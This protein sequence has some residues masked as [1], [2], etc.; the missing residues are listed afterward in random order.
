MNH[1]LRSKLMA[2]ATATCVLAAA[3]APVAAQEAPL[4]TE[5][6]KV[7]YIVGVD[8]GRAIGPA[9]P[10]ID[11]AALKR[12]IENAIAGKPPLLD[13]AQARR[14]S[15]LLMESIIARKNGTAAPA[16]LDRSAVGLLLGDDVGRPRAGIAAEF[17]IPTFLRGLR[18]GANPA[19]KLALDETE[20]SRVRTAF[21]ARVTAERAAARLAKAEA[22]ARDEQAF[23]ASNKDTKGVFTTPSGLQYMILRQG[24]GVRPR[25]G[26]R[27]EVHYEGKLLDGTVFDSSYARGEPAQFGLNQVIAGWTEGL[28]LMPVGAKFRFWIPAR[29]GYGESGAGRDI[30]PNATLTF[31]VELLGVQ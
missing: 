15:Q 29:L 16:A 23:L 6:D 20:I 30:P 12:A 18:D 5:R 11:M 25:P 4:A 14:T 31:D 13:A 8:A 2:V 3:L 27:V 21:A 9:L 22:A 26:Q 19:G 24:D 10:D 28:G 1:P 7:G 17:D